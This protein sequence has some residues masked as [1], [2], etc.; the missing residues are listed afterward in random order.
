MNFNNK[1]VW[2]TGASSGIGEALA[3][4]LSRKGARLILSARRTEQL[5]QVRSR[6]QQPELHHIVRLDLAD[7]ASREAA[8]AGVRG[9]GALDVLI[10]NAGISQRSL[11]C[12]TGLDVVRNLMEV[13]FFAQVILTQG[14]LPDMLARRSGVIVN[15]ASVAGKIGNPRRSGY[16][17]T[18][19]ALIGYMDALRAELKHSGIVICNV[20]P[21]FVQTNISI[22][23]MTGDGSR[24]N[25]MESSIA[26]GIP[27]ARFAERM[28]AAVEAERAETVIT[29]GGKAGLGY[30]AHR[31]SPN[32]YHWI[33]RHVAAP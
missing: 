18:K 28:I 7:S 17:A 1:L 16:C 23:A 3:L 26:R 31:L 5:E 24:L 11:A 14:V 25:Q 13:N 6:C 8:L 22:N 15:V 33:I 29:G 12:D 32:F 27:V 4:A 2:I 9:I 20:C 21:G 19:H 30:W 10:N